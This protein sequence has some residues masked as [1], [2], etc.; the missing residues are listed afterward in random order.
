MR[1]VEPAQAGGEIVV[2]YLERRVRVTIG[3]GSEQALVVAVLERLEG[4][5]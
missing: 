4:A 3:R 5:R 2:E 1:P